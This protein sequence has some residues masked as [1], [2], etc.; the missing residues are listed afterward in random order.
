[1]APEAEAQPAE[2]PS[3]TVV[4]NAQIMS[5]VDVLAEQGHEPANVELTRD[6]EPLAALQFPVERLDG[7]QP[8]DLR[9]RQEPERFGQFAK[10]SPVSF[11]LLKLEDLVDLLDGQEVHP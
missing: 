1:M 3:L 10:P 7:Q 5:A 4:A 2:R 9:L 11:S 6:H 8:R